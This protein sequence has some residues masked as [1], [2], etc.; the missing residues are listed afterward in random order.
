MTCPVSI[1]RPAREV[2][3]VITNRCDIGGLDENYPVPIVFLR[4]PDRLRNASVG[5]PMVG[6]TVGNRKGM[7][8]FG[9]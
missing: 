3:P 6:L 9:G 2:W 8:C 5:Y 7:D 4:N 1:R